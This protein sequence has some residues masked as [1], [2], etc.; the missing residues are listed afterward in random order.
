MIALP[1]FLLRR[2][3][4]TLAITIPVTIAAYLPF[5]DADVTATLVRFGSG[6][7]FNSSIFRI[8]G[9]PFAAAILLVWTALVTVTQPRLPQALALLFAGLLLL[10]PTVH[11]WY[12]GWFL[13]MLP[14]IGA[15]RWTWPLLA[16]SG[17][18]CLVGITYWA[19]AQGGPFEERAWVTIV[20]YSVPFALGLFLVVRGWPSRSS[21][22]APGAG[23][24]A[25]FGVVI[26]CRGER[27]NLKEILPHWLDTPVNEIVVADTPTDDGTERLC[28]NDLRITYLAVPRSG[29][30]AAVRAGLAQLRARVDFAVVCDADH[31]LGSRQVEA[32]L[33]P[34]ADPRVG[35]VC[36]ARVATPDLT[37]AQRF[38]NRLACVLIAF[39]W[40]RHFTDLGPFR[41]VRF[42][43]WPRGAVRDLSYGWNVE[44]NVRALENGMEIVEVALPAGKRP[45]GENIITGTWRGVIGAG[46]GMLSKLYALREESLREQTQREQSQLENTPQE[47]ID[48]KSVV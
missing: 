27:R 21:P 8:V 18:A 14:A 33:A 26:P 12:F 36:G 35:L 1:W 20:E 3:K 38:G 24:T 42:S 48:R 22:I 46:W 9:L 4:E 41:A 29:Y 6:F 25:N 16:W 28:R 5:L 17:T 40:G 47:D 10:S 13:V 15:R 44:M 2:P 37:K 39:G 19:H 32:L 23:A 31:A 11:T 7:E 45:H 43:H 34:F 30:G